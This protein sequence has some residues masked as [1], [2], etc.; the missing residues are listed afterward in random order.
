M[1]GEDF[2]STLCKVFVSDSLETARH[3]CYPELESG[4]VLGL[5]DL[6]N[7]V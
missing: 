5:G 1:L 2:E 4:L 3:V 7:I 6:V